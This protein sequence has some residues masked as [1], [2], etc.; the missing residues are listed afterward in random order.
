MRAVP[1][2][3]ERLFVAVPLP[4]GLLGFVRDC[5]SLLPRSPGLRLMNETQFHVTLAFIGEVEEREAAVARDVVTSVPAHMGGAG[6][7]ER[8]LFIPSARKARVVALDIS[9]GEGVFARLFER[10]MDGLE[11]AG[12][13]QREKRPFHPHLTIA[14]LRDPGPIQ[15][16]SESG[17]ARFAVESVCLYKSEL[18]REGAVYTALAR[19]VLAPAVDH[20]GS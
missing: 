6:R 11:S 17:Q 9:D 16:R 3:S 12:V 2:G 1:G 8:F 18:R 7:I 13:M 20:D 14:R 10:V 19:T 15:P 5:Q 4:A